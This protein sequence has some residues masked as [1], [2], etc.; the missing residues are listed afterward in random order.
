MLK[1]I[2]KEY[3]WDKCTG[4]I[5]VDKKLSKKKLDNLAIMTLRQ[6][7]GYKDDIENYIITKKQYVSPEYDNKYEIEFRYQDKRTLVTSDMVVKTDE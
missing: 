3:L 7:I 4:R 1:I 5:I 6:E 2:V